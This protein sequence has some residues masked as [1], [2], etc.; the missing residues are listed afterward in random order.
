MRAPLVGGLAAIATMV[1]IAFIAQR[2]LADFVP[3]LVVGSVVGLQALYGRA[4]A[5][6]RRRTPRAVAAGLVALAVAGA[7]VSFALTLRYQRTYNP[8]D[9]ALAVILQSW[10]A[11]GLRATP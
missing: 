6:W 9:D 5:D 10:R 4:A 3:F 11:L 8:P 2:Y 7:W 1:T